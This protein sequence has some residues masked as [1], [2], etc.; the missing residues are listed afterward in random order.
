MKKRRSCV[1]FS[2]IQGS[3]GLIWPVAEL[4]KKTHRK[5]QV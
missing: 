3:I 4:E 2:V 5:V 1:S